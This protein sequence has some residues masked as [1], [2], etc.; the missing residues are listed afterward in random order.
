MNETVKLFLS[1]ESAAFIVAALVH[2]GFLANGYE[3]TR[4]GIA[5]T[6]VGTVLAFGLIMILIRPR[7]TQLTALVVQ[8]FAFLGTLV[9]VFTIIIGVGP[10]TVPDVLYHVAIAIV[11]ACGFMVAWRG[12]SPSLIETRSRQSNA[13]TTMPRK[14]PV[15]GRS[16]ESHNRR[17]A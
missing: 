1:L 4:A 16:S 17:R 11:L 8:G 14:E 9:G 13:N 2:F 5:E 6:V 12:R 10:R 15:H 3:H 7:L